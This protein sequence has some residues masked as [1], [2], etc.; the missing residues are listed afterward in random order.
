MHPHEVAWVNCNLGLVR[1]IQGRDDDAFVSFRECRRV[2]PFQMGPDYEEAFDRVVHK[3]EV[4]SIDLPKIFA[5]TDPKY[6][7]SALFHDWCHPDRRG[8][9]AIVRALAQVLK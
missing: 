7:G 5:E 2:W 9:A 8:G 6:R 3:H 4:E 1:L